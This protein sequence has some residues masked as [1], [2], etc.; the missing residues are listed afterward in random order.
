MIFFF[1]GKFSVWMAPMVTERRGAPQLRRCGWLAEGRAR[2]GGKAPKRVETQGP[3]I[4]GEREH[5]GCVGR[6]ILSTSLLLTSTT[7]LWR[8]SLGRNGSGR[9]GQQEAPVSRLRPVLGRERKQVWMWRWWWGWRGV[10]GRQVFPRGLVGTR[11]TGWGAWGRGR[12]WG[13][14]WGGAGWEKKGSHN[15]GYHPQGRGPSLHHST[16]KSLCAKVRRQG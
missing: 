5:H 8:R 3:R 2:K 10:C 11:F 6:G 7:F 12:S 15:S 13:R 4:G 9:D 1:N 14:W 16:Q